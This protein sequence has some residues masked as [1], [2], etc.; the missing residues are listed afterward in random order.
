MNKWPIIIKHSYVMVCIIYQQ[1]QNMVWLIGITFFL[2]RN[3]G[4]D[5]KLYWMHLN[6]SVFAFLVLCKSWMGPLSASHGC[7]VAG[8]R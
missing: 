6:A 3:D 1:Y 7:S 5:R 8:E 4:G 2:H